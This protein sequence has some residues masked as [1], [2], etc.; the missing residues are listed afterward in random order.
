MA[1]TRERT[2]EDTLLPTGAKRE[3][4]KEKNRTLKFPIREKFFLEFLYGSEKK[5]KKENIK[6]TQQKNKENK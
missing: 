1:H 3:R 2:E 4:E 6:K 5:S